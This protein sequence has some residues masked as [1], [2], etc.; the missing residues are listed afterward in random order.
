MASGYNTILVM[1]VIFLGTAPPLWFSLTH[2]GSTH[3]QPLGLAEVKAL[4]RRVQ[5]LEAEMK[6]MRRLLSVDHDVAIQNAS[7]GVTLPSPLMEPQ[8]VCGSGTSDHHGRKIHCRQPQVIPESG[9]PAFTGASG[10]FKIDR[11]NLPNPFGDNEPPCD[12]PVYTIDEWR[13]KNG[14]TMP[15]HPCIFAADPK[16][17][18]EAMVAYKDLSSLLHDFG[19][20]TVTTQPGYAQAGGHFHYVKPHSRVGRVWRLRDLARAWNTTHLGHY[21]SEFNCK[22]HFCQRFIRKVAVPNFFS[23]EARASTNF[24][25]GGPG[26]GLPF[27]R[28]EK[29]FQLLVNGVKGWFLIPPGPVADEL[30]DQVGPFVFPPD[31]F[32]ARV[33]GKRVGMRPLRCAQ[34]PGEVIWLPPLWWHAT[35]NMDSVT[36]AYGQKPKYGGRKPPQKD[37]EARRSIVA[38]FPELSEHDVN[39][40]YS[41]Q[42]QVDSVTKGNSATAAGS[43]EKILG[44]FRAALE[45]SPAEDQR[46]MRETVAFAHCFL[47]ENLR[48][49]AAKCTD[50]A[51]SQNA[52]ACADKWYDTARTLAPEIFRLQCLK[53][54]RNVKDIN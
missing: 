12:V 4:Q 2:T 14:D 42:K 52:N 22:T 6:Y 50:T 25:V 38:R 35:M 20:E 29:T 54:G 48:D 27:H 53:E 45:A 17:A 43:F 26:S 8:P 3:T 15:D 49:I 51:V 13:K 11:G 10:S 24:L 7:S 28:H 41:I 40:W 44:K 30:A 21:Y 46:I 23:A 1:A 34:Y 18:F 32:N 31:G 36:V 37:S 16:T 5:S 39:W 9:H 19:N 33:R 47:G